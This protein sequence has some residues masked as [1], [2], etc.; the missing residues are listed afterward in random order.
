MS[1]QALNPTN[2]VVS[3]P[4]EAH[5]K[6]ERDRKPAAFQPVVEEAADEQKIQPEELLDKIKELTQD[7][8]YQVRFEMNNEADRLVISLLDGETGEVVRQIPPEELLN[9]IEHLKDLRG[10]LVNSEG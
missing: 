5:E 9:M 8:M 6:V 7:G 4:P 1:V 10:N 2:P 3:N